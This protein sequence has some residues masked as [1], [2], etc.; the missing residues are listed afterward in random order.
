VNKKNQNFI[1]GIE[2]KHMMTEVKSFN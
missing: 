1:L 2:D